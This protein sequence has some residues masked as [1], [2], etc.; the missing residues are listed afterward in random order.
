MIYS[1]FENA[2]CRTSEIVLTF[3]SKSNLRITLHLTQVN[4][5]LG[6]I[7]VTQDRLSS[8][9]ETTESVKIAIELSFVTWMDSIW[10]PAKYLNFYWVKNIHSRDILQRKICSVY[11]TQWTYC[12]IFD[13]VICQHFWADVS[14]EN[15]SGKN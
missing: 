1:C 9:D 8:I 3:D 14:L 15:Q 13:W 11:L 2:N 4:S 12:M 5:G 10:I 7:N 6:Q